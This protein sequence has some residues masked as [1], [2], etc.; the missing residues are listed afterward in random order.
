MEKKLV[1]YGIIYKIIIISLSM[2]INIKHYDTSNYIIEKKYVKT[3]LLN[4]CNWDSGINFF[5]ISLFP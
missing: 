1:R 4:F 3:P 5:K 2:L